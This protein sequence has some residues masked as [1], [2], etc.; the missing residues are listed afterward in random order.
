MPSGN[1]GTTSI[2][3]SICLAACILLVPLF[4]H[5]SAVLGV[6][7]ANAEPV[8]VTQP[9]AGCGEITDVTTSNA[10]PLTLKSLLHSNSGGIRRTSGPMHRGNCREDLPGCC[11][12]NPKHV[13][14]FHSHK[15][16]GSSVAEWLL[17]N[18]RANGMRAMDKVESLKSKDYFCACRYVDR[19][20][21]TFTEESDS[22]YC[23]GY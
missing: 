7:L 23:C 6:E 20:C 9:N 12:R 11:P 19:E 16:G 13:L 15:T 14:F 17:S 8:D 21:S 2:V 22:G 18:G 3:I 5:R 10:V 1:R 4:L